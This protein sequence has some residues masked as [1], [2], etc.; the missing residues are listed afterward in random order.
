LRPEALASGLKPCDQVDW[1][2]FSLSLAGYNM[3][4]S[5]L[6]SVGCLIGLLW[7]RRKPVR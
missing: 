6:L 2:L 7:L 5:A 4:A 1:R 3:L